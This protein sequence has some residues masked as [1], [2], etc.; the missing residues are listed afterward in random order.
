MPGTPAALSGLQLADSVAVDP[1]KWLYAPLEA[2]CA[3]VR[4]PVALRNAFSYHPSYYNFE[5]EGHELL[6]HAAEMRGFR[7]LKVWLALQH[8]GVSG[9]REMIRDDITLAA[10]LYDLARD[11]AEFEALTN[12]LSITTLRYVPR[13]LQNSVDLRATNDYSN[14]LNQGLLT[15]IENSGEAFISSALVDGKYAL[16]F[17]IVNLRASSA[18]IEAMPPLVVK[19]GRRVHAEL[20]GAKAIEQ[21]VPR[22]RSLG[23]GG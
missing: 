8:A 1:H 22:Q 11:R 12:H 18:D 15:A 9:Y 20:R 2:G 3:F 19:L 16:R 6:R 10:Y 23:G 5:V 7:A 4:D 13:E 21:G 17:C 14:R